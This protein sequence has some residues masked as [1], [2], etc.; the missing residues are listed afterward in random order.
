[1]YCFKFEKAFTQTFE[2]MEHGDNRL[3]GARVHEWF[4]DGRQDIKDGR[5]FG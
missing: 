2:V 3:S 5:Y 1:M 4:K